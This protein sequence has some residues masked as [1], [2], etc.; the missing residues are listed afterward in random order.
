MNSNSNPHDFKDGRQGAPRRLTKRLH[1]KFHV[2]VVA[3]VAWF[4]LAVWSFAGSGLV[5][6]LLVVVSGFMFVV[7]A[8]MLILSR[9]GHADPA[10]PHDAEAPREAEL[11]LRDWARWNYDTQTGPLA[12]AQAA[13]QILLPIAAAAIGMTIIGLL[14]A[15]AGH[16]AA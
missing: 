14:F 1:P 15:F 4:A 8:L 3:L 16:P 2:I 10:A 12:G 11:S 9:V 7:V 5:D 13:T 6:Y